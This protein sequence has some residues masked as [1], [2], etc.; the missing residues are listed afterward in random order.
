MSVILRHRAD[1]SGCRVW[2]FVEISGGDRDLRDSNKTNQ[3]NDTRNTP[4]ISAGP[5]GL[6]ASLFVALRVPSPL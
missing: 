1:F 6:A 2:E 5:S 4:Q 3:S